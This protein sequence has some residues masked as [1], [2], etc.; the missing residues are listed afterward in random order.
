MTSSPSSQRAQN[1]AQHHHH[2]HHLVLIHGAWAGAWVWNAVT[3]LLEKVGYTVHAVDLPGNR[4]EIP[5][6]TV[7]LDLYCDYIQTKVLGPIFD[8]TQQQQPQQQQQQPQQQ[9]PKVTLVA[10]SGAG[11]IALQ[12]AENL[13]PGQSL[14][15]I[16]IVAGMLLPP[17]MT[18]SQFRALPSHERLPSKEPLELIFTSDGSLSTVTTT[19]AIQCFFQDLPTN[20]AQQAAANLTAQPTGGLNICANYNPGTAEGGGTGGGRGGVRR[21]PILYLEALRDASVVLP[22][23]RAMHRAFVQNMGPTTNNNNNNTKDHNLLTVMSIDTG[24]V[25]HVAQP[26]RFCQMVCDY[27]QSVSSSSSSS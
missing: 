27:I 18:F 12:L 4:G 16:V 14:H 20:M 13:G 23:Q 9:G 19:S 6:E 5:P 26:E 15:S 3:P 21:T 25:P 10:H 7:T 1:D 2:Y 24:H 17:S 22:L 8:Q 11:V